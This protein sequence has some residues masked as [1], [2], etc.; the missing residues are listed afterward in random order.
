MNAE[1]FSSAKEI[2]E[3]RPA[4]AVTSSGLQPTEE[5]TMRYAIAL[6]AVLTALAL[7]G[8]A[9]AQSAQSG[10]Y[11]LTG[12]GGTGSVTG[13]GTG[14][15]TGG[16]TGSAANCSFQTMAAC[17][18]SKS[19]ANQTCTPNPQTTGSGLKEKSKQQ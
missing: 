19:G 15:V 11:C 6:T 7:S 4:A 13:G 5:I 3:R 18:K 10:K 1:T 9:N 17:E 14:S 2:P 16:G 8:P 12:G